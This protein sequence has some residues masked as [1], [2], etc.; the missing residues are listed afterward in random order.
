M[1][2]A[3]INLFLSLFSAQNIYFLAVFSQNIRPRQS[4]AG[5]P[6]LPR[7]GRAQ[8]GSGVTGSLIVAGDQPSR[9]Q[10]RHCDDDECD[11]D[12]CNDDDDNDDECNDDDDDD[13]E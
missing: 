9:G 7:M 3:T 4:E 5:S 10:L 6:A 13:D 2:I 1:P 12:E 11:D 8:S